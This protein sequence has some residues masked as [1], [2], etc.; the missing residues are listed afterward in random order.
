MTK[1]DAFQAENTGAWTRGAAFNFELRIAEYLKWQN[2][3]H[4]DGT[5]A[6]LRNAGW[7]FELSV[8]K[9]QIQPFYFHHSQHAL[10]SVG[11]SIKYPLEDKYGLRFVFFQKKR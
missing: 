8:D 5:Q 9:W 2:H 11:D 1:R 3:V 6:Q 4:M 7:Q 10:D